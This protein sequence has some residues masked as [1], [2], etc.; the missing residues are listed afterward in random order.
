[1]PISWKG[2][3][4]QYVGRLHME[5]E[6]KDKVIVYDYLDNMKMLERMYERRLEGYKMVG[7]DVVE[8]E[9]F[10]SFFYPKKSSKSIDTHQNKC[11]HT[12]KKNIGRRVITK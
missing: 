7:Y 5:H 6:G 11:Y 8:N 10:R 12:S 3:I 1:M 4:I 9:I 2:R